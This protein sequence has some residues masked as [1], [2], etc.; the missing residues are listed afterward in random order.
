MNNNNKKKTALVG[1]FPKGL[2]LR[3]SGDK[4]KRLEYFCL[5]FLSVYTSLIKSTFLALLSGLGQNGERA[6]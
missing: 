6:V 4:C 2:L 1:I 3:K 5:L